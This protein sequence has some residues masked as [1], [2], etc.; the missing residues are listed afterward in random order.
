MSGP[1]QPKVVDED[2]SDERVKSFLDITP[3]DETDPDYHVLLKAYQGM[4]PENFERFV[5]FFVEANRNINACS[6]SGQS[7]LQH[8]S[9]HSRSAAY[10]DILKNAGAE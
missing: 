4:I 7:I 6:L 10:V 1:S 9:G 8:V 2:W 5:A 3:Y